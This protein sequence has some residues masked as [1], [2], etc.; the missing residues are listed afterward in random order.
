MMLP[1]L[2][3]IA[4]SYKRPHYCIPT[5][6]AFL[7]N[8]RYD[9]EIKYAVVDGGS[10]PWMLDMFRT[11]FRN[12]GKPLTIVNSGNISQMVNASAEIGGEVWLT[13]LDDFTL[14]MQ[15]DVT[16]DVKFL[17]EHSDVGH[18]RMGRLAF[19]DAPPA[20]YVADLRFLGRAAHAWV[21]DKRRCELVTY[22]WTLGFG[23]THRRMWDAYGPVRDVGMTGIELVMNEQFRAKPDGPTV[24]IPIRFGADGGLM[25]MVREPVRHWGFVRTDEYTAEIGGGE[26]RWGA[27]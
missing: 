16:N 18:I 27:V 22:A 11:I 24:A 26:K 17:L 12:A 6:Q 15:V 20:K 3:C 7:N 1:T 9:G 19:Y 2:T 25:Q 5:L 21:L 14:E 4:L 8:V 13:A 10:E 23:I